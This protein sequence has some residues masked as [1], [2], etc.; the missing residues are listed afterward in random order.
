M[1]NYGSRYALLIGL[2]AG[3]AVSSFLF[4]ISLFPPL[5]ILLFAAGFQVLWHPLALLSI[6]GV[7]AYA[8]WKSGKTITPSLLKNRFKLALTSLR[9]TA[10]VNI[11]LYVLI[12]LIFVVGAITHGEARDLIFRLP[13]AALVLLVFFIAATLFTTITVGLLIVHLTQKKIKLI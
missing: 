2:P 12:L 8:L 6:V 11:H 5:D 13:I 9:F 1:K 3:L 10:M 4:F 7:Y